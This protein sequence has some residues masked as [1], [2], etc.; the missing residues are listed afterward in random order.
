MLRLAE[1]WTLVE[2]I[3]NKNQ[4]QKHT[5]CTPVTNGHSTQMTRIELAQSNTS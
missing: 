2:M 1:L 5:Y 4:F 3:L